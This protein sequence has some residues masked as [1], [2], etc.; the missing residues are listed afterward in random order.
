MATRALE[1]VKKL[2]K[3]DDANIV[4]VWESNNLN[5]VKLKCLFTTKKEYEPYQTEN[6]IK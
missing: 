1:A 4:R 2:K 6:N 3:D 5:I